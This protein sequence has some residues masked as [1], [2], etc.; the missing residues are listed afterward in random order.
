MLITG[1]TIFLGVALLLVKLPR[2]V[3]LQVL[4]HDLKLD[5]AVTALVLLIHWGAPICTGCQRTLQA[6]IGRNPIENTI[7]NAV[8]WTALDA[9][10]WCIGG[11][12]GNRTRVRK[13]STGRS[14][15]LVR[16]FCALASVTPTEQAE[17]W[18]VALI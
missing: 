5:L 3:M 14:T 10:G 4:K 12:G 8:T 1:L 18:R 2:R 6:L 17:L 16:C 13:P 11:G 9:T 15:Y 7:K